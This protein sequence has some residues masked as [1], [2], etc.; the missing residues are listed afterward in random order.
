MQFQARALR[1]PLLPDKGLQLVKQ[2]SA[3]TRQECGKHVI[4]AVIIRQERAANYRRSPS[5]VCRVARAALTR[6]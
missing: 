4:I 3:A 5:I 1:S 2:L 6:P